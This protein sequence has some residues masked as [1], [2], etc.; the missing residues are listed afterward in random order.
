ML[1]SGKLN[2]FFSLLRCQ[3]QYWLTTANVHASV[4]PRQHTHA[5]PSHTTSQHPAAALVLSMGAVG[6]PI[7]MW[8]GCAPMCV[9]ALASQSLT[10]VRLHILPPHLST[11]HVIPPLS[12]VTGSPLAPFRAQG[13]PNKVVSHINGQAASL[14]VPVLS[15]LQLATALPTPASVCR[16]VLKSK[17]S[18]TLYPEGGL[19][20]ICDCVAESWEG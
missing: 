7:C 18:S 2:C 10:P 8:R 17:E 16:C 5:P 9:P 13:S 11:A 15:H 12:P 14:S 20:R 4:V 3:F 6:V 1:F 19:M